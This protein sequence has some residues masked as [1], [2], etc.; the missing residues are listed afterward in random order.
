[1]QA[2]LQDSDAW[3][4]LRLLFDKG[5]LH[6]STHCSPDLTALMAAFSAVQISQLEFAAR[7]QP[8]MGSIQ[9]EFV[10]CRRHASCRICLPRPPADTT[11][12]HL[13]CC[14]D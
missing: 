3:K 12:Q 1:M 10:L 2:S 14:I 5:T 9:R 4:A 8:L 6:F 7:L 13:T 11:A